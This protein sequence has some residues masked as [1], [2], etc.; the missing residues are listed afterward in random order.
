VIVWIPD[1]FVDPAHRRR[2][3]ARALLDACVEAARARGCHRLNLESGHQRAEA[4][5]L[6]ETYGFEHAG[7]LYTL[8]L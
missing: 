7:R 5:R 4:H 1:L 2:G 8:R 3:L 6:Y